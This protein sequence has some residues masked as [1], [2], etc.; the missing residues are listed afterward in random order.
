MLNAPGA[1]QRPDSPAQ[2]SGEPGAGRRFPARALPRGWPRTFAGRL[3]LALAVLL[4]A[5]GAIVVLLGRQAMQRDHD[6][7]LQRLSYRLAAHIVAHW[8]DIQAADASAAERAA[9]DQVL[10]MLMVVNPGVQ[11]YVLD[12]QGGVQA[13]LGDAGRQ[14]LPPVD[15][16][17]LR[18]FLEGAALPLRSTD[19]MAPGAQ[20]L[21]SVARFPPRPGSAQPA[22]YLYVVLDGAA[23]AQ[24]AASLGAHRTWAGLSLA[25]AGGLLLTLLAGAYTV[26]RLTLPL[27]R[28][29]Q[30]MH[31]YAG[32][33]AL[34][35]A[36]AGAG[37]G[38]GASAAATLAPPASHASAT[39][40][41][42]AT[43]ATSAATGVALGDEV[44]QLAEAF[45]SLTQRLQ[46][47]AER[48]RAHDEAH[49]ETLAGLAHDLRT[50]LT[51]LH[52][53]L[54]ALSAQ[55]EGLAAPQIGP[56]GLAAQAP[57]GAAPPTAAGVPALL[58]AA[59]AQSNKVR[60]L[61]QQLFELASLQSASQ[62][63]QTERFAL[64]ELVSDAVRKFE[65]QAPQPAVRLVG[66]PPGRLELDGDLGLIER[67][68][69][70]LID[71]ALRH[72]GSAGPVRVSLRRSGPRAEVWVEDDGPGLPAE[73]QRR[74][75]QGLSLRQ[76][77]LP[78]GPGAS[79]TSGMSGAPGATGSA[80][81]AGSPGVPGVPG[82]PV[83]AAVGAGDARGSG[84]SGSLGGLGGLGLAIAQRVAQLHGGS[85]CPLPSPAGG[86][87]LCLALPLVR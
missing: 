21:F 87:R 68:L 58:A 18:R 1:D 78:R 55:A 70:N 15:L 49:R 11:V 62:L 52:G 61:S 53:H 40:A 17:P 71:N 57:A 46:A 39:P 74:L 75:L 32:P 44:Q 51:A 73:L 26:R 63:A 35:D 7:M 66:P 47:Q 19:P 48:Q 65:L 69:T 14:P 3:A 24:V 43:S 60:Q 25:A 34:A 86:T 23:R 67:A 45:D 85:L 27:H 64:D 76:P 82:V 42:S 38:A 20:R 30:R 6:E 4:L 16:A 50:P 37:A 56:T 9:R 81:S 12:A 2:G 5:Y 84:G 72:A 8:P 80:G 79:G 59:L 41:T 13:Y 10:D 36:H 29:A 28:L 33:P 22:G 54:E 77:P 83:G 31:R